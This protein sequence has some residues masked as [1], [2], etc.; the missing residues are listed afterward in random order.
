VLHL[1]DAA[2]ELLFGSPERDRLR[3]WARQ[4]NLPRARLE[5][6]LALARER[7]FDVDRLCFAEHISDASP[8]PQ[9]FPSRN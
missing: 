6:L 4:P 5:A 9:D 1:D 7:G 8:L 2:T 3:L